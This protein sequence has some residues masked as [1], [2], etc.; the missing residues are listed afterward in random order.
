MIDKIKKIIN[1]IR[2]FESKLNDPGKCSVITPHNLIKFSELIN[3][4]PIHGKITDDD[5]IPM[6]HKLDDR[7]Y[8]TCFIRVKDLKSYLKE[9]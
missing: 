2:K 9:E 7:K 6:S 5:I 8:E 1:D 4:F 3:I